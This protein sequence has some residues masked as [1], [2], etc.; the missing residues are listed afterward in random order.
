MIKFLD[1]NHPKLKTINLKI[2]TI[3]R[4]LGRKTESIDFYKKAR[5]L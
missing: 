3:L 5:E 2:A 1:S 4:K